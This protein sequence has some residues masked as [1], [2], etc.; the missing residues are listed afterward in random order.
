MFYVYNDTKELNKKK[1][2]VYKESLKVLVSD[3]KKTDFNI[4]INTNVYIK[5][6]IC[7][8]IDKLVLNIYT[9]NDI[10][11]KL[12]EKEFCNL[13]K[14]YGLINLLNLYI[15]STNQILDSYLFNKV[16]EPSK[17]VHLFD[18]VESYYKSCALLA[19]I[20]LFAIIINND[21]LNYRIDYLIDNKTD[22]KIIKNLKK[23]NISLAKGLYDIP[24]FLTMNEIKTLKNFLDNKIPTKEYMDVYSVILF[25][26]LSEILFFKDEY[27]KYFSFRYN[28][29]LEEL[30]KKKIFSMEHGVVK[31]RK[32]LPPKGGV[33]LKVKNDDEIESIYFNEK[34]D[35]NNRAVAG[36]VRYTDGTEE[37]FIFI[38]NSLVSSNIFCRCSEKVFMALLLFYEVDY[39]NFDKIINRYGKVEF[40]VLSPYYWKYRKSN[41]E[42]TKEKEQR[43]QGKKVKKEYTVKIST[44]IRKIKGNPSKEAQELAERLCVKL[45]PN[46]TIV[47]EH[48]RTYNKTNN[49]KV[50]YNKIL[51]VLKKL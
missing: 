4:L 24:V 21:L 37:D 39:K 6:T 23:E 51:D 14:K 46:F 26:S 16:V 7:S 31:L 50:D 49:N 38:L 36:V 30:Y 19:K 10:N 35:I 40:D 22:Y 17:Q 32:V 27:K 48:S 34:E 42:T 47:R 29:N 28:Y 25:Q 3:I 41:Y 1:T 33:I 5:S 12:I 15:V 11:Y 13:Y 44:F 20:S 9:S 18:D 2:N 43:L 45:E 8:D